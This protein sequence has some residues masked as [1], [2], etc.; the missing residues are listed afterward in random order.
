[1]IQTRS[2]QGNKAVMET[3]KTRD[4]FHNQIEQ[5]QQ[6]VH[7][8]R[9]HTDD[10]AGDAHEILTQVAPVSTRSIEDCVFTTVTVPWWLT[11]GSIVNSSQ[12]CTVDF[13]LR[14]VIPL[15]L[16][17]VTRGGTCGETL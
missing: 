15:Q 7:P 14:E 3:E 13:D 17:V 4:E 8:K 12:L 16:E 2:A 9:A 10:D 11:C 5:I 1:M 6:R